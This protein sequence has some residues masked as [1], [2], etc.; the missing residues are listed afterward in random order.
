MKNTPPGS[1]DSTEK[2]RDLEFAFD[3]GHSSIGWAVLRGEP[4]E[5]L[6]CGSVIFQSDDCLASKRRDFR[7]QR[8]HVRAT[9]LRLARLKRVF[10]HAQALNEADFAAKRLH[11]HAAPWLLAAKVLASDGAHKLTWSE[12]W[13]VLSWYAHNRGYDGNRDWSRVAEEA[14]AREDAEK[15]K[16]AHALYEKYGT[17]T[18]A[19]TWCRMCGLDPFGTKIAA[20]PSGN[21]RP[22]GRNA[23][24]PREDVAAEVRRILE[25]HCGA[26]PGLD[27]RLVEGIMTDAG[28]LGLAELRLPRRYRGGVLFGQLVPRFENRIIAICPVTFERL[29][30]EEL[31]VSGDA[32]AA[33]RRAERMAKVPSADTPEF[34][35]YRWAMQ[36]ANIQVVTPQGLRRLT[37]SE[38]RE[39]HRQMQER[40][41]FTKTELKKAVRALT[42]SPQDNLNQMLSHP[43]AEKA[44]VLDPVQ[45]LL[46]GDLA[47]WF[48]VLPEALQKRLRG[49]LR[50]GRRVTLAEVRQWLGADTAAFDAVVQ[51]RVDAAATRRTKGGLTLTAEEIFAQ[52][53]QVRSASG[54]A[55]HTR[56]L[57]NDVVK[58]V[59]ETN[60]HPTEEG[61]P[62]YRS[63]EI[64]RAQLE[65]AI[66]EKTNNHLVRHRI[67]ILDRLHRDL[68]RA[69]AGDD[70]S[71]VV[72]VTIEVNRDLRQFSGKTAKEI[73]QDMGLRLGNFNRVAQKL[74]EVLK[75]MGI[76]VTPGLIRKA[77]IADDLGWTCPYT[78]KTFDILDLVH[79]RVDKD[80]IIPRS[81]RPSDSLDSLVIT[82]NEVNRLKGKR[83]AYRFIEQEGG[84]AVPAMTHVEIKPLVR[85]LAD[86]KALDSRR[87]H[88]DDIKRKRK[89]KELL[90]LPDY[91][92]KEF[93]PRDL[94]QTSQL[95]RLGAEA[96]R[97]PYANL[98][99]E[100]VVTSL[101]G[102]VTAVLRKGWNL[103][104]CLAAANPAVINPEDVDENGLPR[105]H[106]KTEIRKI[107][108]LHHALDAC[109]IAFASR[110]LPRDGGVWELL[111][112]RSLNAEEQKKLRAA[113]GE[114]AK[115][116]QSGSLRIAELSADLKEQVRERLAERRVVQHVPSDLTG[117]RAEL[118][119]WRVIQVANGVA[120]L[121]QRMRQPDG[122]R[123]KKPEAKERVEKL[124]GL[125]PGK[126]HDLKAALIVSDNYGLVLDPEPT[127]IPFHKVWSRLQELKARNGGKPPRVLRNGMII[128]LTKGK[129]PGLWR[130]FSIK[131]AR[132]GILID[133]GRPDVVRLKNKTE[134]H[135]INA[136]YASLVRDGLEIVDTSFASAL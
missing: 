115:F 104:G 95:V 51:A 93:T 19:E 81:E 121:R 62:L 38:R 28:R 2:L 25:A 134:G 17:R 27:E 79:R 111:V 63:E 133:L 107:T 12:I 29:F 94:T 123:P 7:R 37:A 5:L 100:P 132:A 75:P 103:L 64:R 114:W 135:W 68:V 91:V 92:E 87:G 60:R 4:L 56:T 49:K 61:G 30:Q 99:Q 72:R 83:T 8:R 80:H 6:G 89:R 96:L 40:G 65:R 43:E 102:S 58:F 84:K 54:R 20:N 9:R 86:V 105:V 73:A 45:K 14:S 101:P 131:N 106:T 128:R 67:K 78:G 82:F 31:A 57:M 98:P 34:R 1:A 39:V 41:A 97:K 90:E 32:E 22:K 69:Y 46:A 15:V 85:Y 24:F 109:T 77:R 124:V 108:H 118:N 88:E 126:L 117:M 125:K 127:I 44:L 110:L 59:L 136:L 66:D 42:G 71:R 48:G 18:M 113:L 74:E 16:N 26:L 116:D 23:A 36:L 52:A 119:A 70:W 76:P 55:P 35:N 3:V 53:F 50:L 47:P 130:V 10:L 13:D 33:K 122:S 120:T 112:K 11:P 21:D 129:K